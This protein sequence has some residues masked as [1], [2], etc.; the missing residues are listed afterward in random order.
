VVVGKT[1]GFNLQRIRYINIALG[2]L[3]QKPVLYQLTITEL[4]QKELK[5]EHKRIQELKLTVTE[6]A[7]PGT[8]I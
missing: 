2:Y 6:K 7:L 1:D 3:L 5:E 4:K 8:D